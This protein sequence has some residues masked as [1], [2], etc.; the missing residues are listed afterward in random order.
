MTYR[1]EFTSHDYV[2]IYRYNWLTR[3]IPYRWH[4]V[5]GGY[6]EP[7]Y[8]EKMINEIRQD[9]E[10]QQKKPLVGSVD[11]VISFLEQHS[12]KDPTT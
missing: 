11:V 6:I 12:K 1:L 7:P 3:F 8:I 10:W 4:Y 5:A 2:R 9:I